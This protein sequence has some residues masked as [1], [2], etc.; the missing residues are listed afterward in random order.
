MDDPAVA[1]VMVSELLV[2]DS[3]TLWLRNTEPAAWHLALIE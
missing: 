3:V 1:L 2:V